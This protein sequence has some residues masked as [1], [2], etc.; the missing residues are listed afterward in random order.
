MVVEE[1]NTIGTAWLRLSMLPEDRQPA[2]RHEFRKY[3]DSRINFY[4]SMTEIPKARQYLR[5]GEGIQ[6][7]IWKQAVEASSAASSPV[8]ASL[9]LPP[10]NAMIDTTTTGVMLAQT[11]LPGLI[12][13]L[14]GALMLMCALLSGFESAPNASRSWVHTL[15]FAL[16]LAM[17]LYVILDLDYPRL[18]LIRIDDA[19]TALIELK[20]KFAG[21]K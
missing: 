14:L 5:V 7:D 11:H 9:V 6:D 13:V 12:S 17:T 4:S 20:A 1:A 18:G 15:V 2:L 19:D 3:L 8:I 16:I 21:G 10:I